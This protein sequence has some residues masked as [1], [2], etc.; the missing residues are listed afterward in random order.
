[1]VATE[2]YKLVEL[3]VDSPEYVRVSTSF[4]RYV[5]HF[6][7]WKFCQSDQLIGMLLMLRA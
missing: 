4:C 6:M 7:Q 3:P 5:T 2:N 1:M